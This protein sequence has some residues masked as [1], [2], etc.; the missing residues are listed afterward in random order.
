MAAIPESARLFMAGLIERARKLK[1]T[2]AFPEGGDA[3]V[4]EAAARLAREGVVRPV[5]IGPQ[6]AHAPEGV[7]FADP[8]NSPLLSKY[9]ALYHERRRAKGVTQM[10]AAEI[11]RKPLYFAALMVAAGDADGT[12]GGAANSTAETVR[13]ALHC[14]GPHARARLVSSVFIMA[15]QDRSQG[16]NGL[17]AFADCAVVIDPTSMQLADIAVA[18]AESARVLL[19][20]EPVVALLSFSTKGSAKHPQVDTVVEALEMLRAREPDLNV[21]GELQADA[22]VSVLVGQSKAPGSKAAG[23]ANTLIFPNL[24]AGNIGY[25]LLERLGGATAIGPFLQGLAKPANDLSR[26]CSAEDIFNVAVVTA[27]QSETM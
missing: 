16:H 27:L 6:P 17:M 2:I 22:A 5:L 9:A 14:I 13:A 24:A 1:K 3:R 18:T 4:L 10:E 23:R 11:A 7:V 12:V 25:K 20:T 21:D 15:L 19:N 8:P 26:G